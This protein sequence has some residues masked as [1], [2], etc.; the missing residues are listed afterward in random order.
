MKCLTPFKQPKPVTAKFK[1]DNNQYE[2]S[3][4]KFNNAAVMAMVGKKSLKLHTSRAGNQG[5]LLKVSCKVNGGKDVYI[6]EFMDL[7]GIT[8]ARA[9]MRGKSLFTKLVGQYPA[10]NTEAL[11]LGRDFLKNLPNRVGVV[12]S[13]GFWKLDLR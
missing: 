4:V 9:R 10:D 2:L 13:G 6:N 7:T 8:G 5:L 11:K 3:N 1:E 12:K